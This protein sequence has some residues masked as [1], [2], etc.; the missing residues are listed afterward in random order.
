MRCRIKEDWRNNEMH[1]EEEKK[2]QWML[3]YND[4]RGPVVNFYLI[5]ICLLANLSIVLKYVGSRYRG[6]STDDRWW[7]IKSPHSFI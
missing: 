3:E 4:V 6:S 7:H 5:A 2:Y 1:T